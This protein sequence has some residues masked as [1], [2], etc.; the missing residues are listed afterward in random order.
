M[1]GGTSDGVPTQ[2]RARLPDLGSTGPVRGSPG[3]GRS[4]QPAWLVVSSFW[5]GGLLSDDLQPTSALSLPATHTPGGPASLPVSLPTSPVQH[6]P[7]RWGGDS[8]VGGG[9]GGGQ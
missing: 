4:G 5:A 8:V 2:V 9:G 3:Y 6:W 1:D 7:Q